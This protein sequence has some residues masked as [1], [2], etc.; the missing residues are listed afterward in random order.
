LN[1]TADTLVY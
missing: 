1:T